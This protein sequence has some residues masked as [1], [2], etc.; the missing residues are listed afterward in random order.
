MDTENG[1]T[2]VCSVG[3][4]VSGRVD[5]V[6]PFGVF[7]QLAGNIRAYIRRR[8]LSLEGDI[9]PSALV[10]EGQE[11]KAV[12]LQLAEPGKSME[13]SRR[14]LLH[15]P[16]REFADKFH[17][18]D[19]VTATVRDLAPKGV[20]VRVAAG[21]NGFIPLDELAPW[22]IERPEDVVWVGDRLEAEITEIDQARREVRLSIR[23][24]MERLSRVEAI[25]CLLYTS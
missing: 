11:I 3:Q 14:P 17:R 1:R 25:I 22:K 16:W 9:D 20:F 8:E 10:A 13:L 5:R 24:R 21:V 12:V 15:D 7:V 4:I 6:L 2:Q 23:R 19:V 18:G